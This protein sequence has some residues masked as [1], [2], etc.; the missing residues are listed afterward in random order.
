MWL[1]L[2]LDCQADHNA[3]ENNRY[4]ANENHTSNDG[5]PSVGEMFTIGSW[6][7]VFDGV[8]KDLV[9]DIQSEMH[10]KR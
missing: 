5:I 2:A 1:P 3:V 8:A 4:I 10:A 9:R 6:E 7:S